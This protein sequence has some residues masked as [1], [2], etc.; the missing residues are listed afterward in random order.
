MHKPRFAVYSAAGFVV[1]ML[2]MAMASAPPALTQV[3]SRG[4]QPLATPIPVGPPPEVRAQQSGPWSV[5]INGTPNVN[6]ANPV[7]GTFRDVEQPA[8]NPRQDGTGSVVATNA[9]TTEAPLSSVPNGKQLVIEYFSATAIV[10]S[11]QSGF[12][13][14]TT[15]AGGVAL[16][17]HVPVIQKFA[18]S[19]FAG[20]DLLVAGQPVRIYADPGTTLS[21]SFRRSNNAGPSSFSADISGYFV[22]L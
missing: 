22:N 16:L 6:V 8:R 9:F 21:V 2:G 15:R 17:H 7:S 4:V 12:F 18:D 5:G 14:I 10:P 13:F 1:V 11:G 19:A 20:S 3:N